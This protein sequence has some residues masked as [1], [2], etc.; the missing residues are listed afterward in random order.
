MMV[1]RHR[2]LLTLMAMVA[3]CG[4][5]AQTSNRLVIP[6]VTVSLGQTQLPVNIENTDEIVAAQF[7]LTLPT[8]MTAEAV[9]ALSARGDDHQVTVRSMGGQRWRVLLYSPQNRPLKGQSGVVMYIPINIPSSYA[10]GSEHQLIIS[11]AT[12]SNVKT[13][14]VLTETLAG[15]VTINKLP[16]LTAKSVTADRTTLTPGETV[17]VSWQVENIGGLATGG[18]WSEQV[19]L[20]SADGY[21]TKLMATT[22]YEG[23]L[24]A[25]G[26]VSRQAEIVVPMLLGIDGNAR[27]QVSIVTG[28][29][30]GESTAAQA[31]NTKQGDALLTVEKRLTLELQPSKVQENANTRITA[32]LNRSGSWSQEQTY[33]LT[34]LS[35]L[36]AETATGDSR[37]T[38]PATVTMK[39]GQSGAVFYLQVK[40][41]NTLDENSVVVIT[42][43][44]NGYP[45]ATAQLVIEDNEYPDL[46]LTA[47]KSVL[48]EGETFQLTIA[49]TP[50]VSTSD[51]PLDITLTSENQKRFSLPQTVTIPAGETTATVEVTAIDD[52]LPS[53]DLSN[54]FTASAPGYNK[55]EVIVLLKDNDMPVL[56]LQ[57]TPT[58]VQE[59]AGPIAVAGIL[60]RTSNT[61]SKITVKLTDD[62]E[63]GLYFGN[64]T[65]ELAKGV[66]EVHFNF[67]PVD[68]ATVDG[69]RTYTVTAAVWLSSCSCGASGESAGYVSAQLQVLD[70]DEWVLY[71]GDLYDKTGVR[72]Y[73]NTCID[74]DPRDPKH[75]FVSGRTGLY[76][77]NDGKF[78]K[79]WNIDNSPLQYAKDVNKNYTLILSI[80]F[81]NEGNLWV[82]DSQAESVSLL[83]YT[84]DGKWVDHHRSEL[85]S[86]DRSMGGMRGSFFDSRGLLWF[87]NDHH[88]YPAFFCYDTK[89]DKLYPYGTFINEDET[90]LEPRN[91][92]CIGE[93]K[94]GNIWIGTTTGPLMLHAED[95]LSDPETVRL[96]QIKVPRNDGTNLAD[97]LLADIDITT[98]AVDGAGRK[99]FGTN[100]MGVYLISE[101]NMAEVQHFT[102]TGSKLLSDNIESM[103]INDQTGEVF[104]G[105]SYGLCSYMSDA[106]VP[107][108][109]MTKESVWAYPNPVRPD[110]TGLITI[111]GL[112]YN[113][114]V[115]ICASNGALVAEGRS[116]GG[117]FTWDG[118]D[119]KGKRVASGVYMVLTAKADGSKGVVC[120][121]AIVN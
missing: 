29:S 35:G 54:A 103:A 74:V 119:T 44:G 28:E 106:T 117:M 81:D 101:D 30:T 95:V 92:R 86:V 68:N 94:S 5:Q 13:E 39:A 80:K 9:G 22:Y 107:A 78:L 66:E 58:T 48:T 27:L 53:L 75:V 99:W 88:G 73:D 118:R 33:T 70:N 76:E 37:L 4:M 89:A 60:R 19:S 3:L 120:K 34:A 71:E 110:Y 23:T 49:T 90:V 84:A 93:D 98:I 16:D 121:I 15:K 82:F 104:I 38:V 79:L 105:T 31:N 46:T 52:E 1:L 64:R 26:V 25:K 113:A 2:I 36:P 67:G 18:G 108:E 111:T 12:L 112:T 14:N 85:I 63:G 43:K 116:S 51:S 10:E 11:D 109:E 17:V 83:E 55:A 62:A 96:E 100:G 65:L 87:V 8:G 20:V 40:D 114:D 41:N 59:S 69:D 47:S 72:Y 102:M 91:V 6:D 24:D 57:I 56:E 45:E 115:K 42:A 97:Y 32:K 61:N 7:D 77:F 21:T 50:D